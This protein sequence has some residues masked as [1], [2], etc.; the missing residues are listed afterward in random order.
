[1]LLQP[2]RGVDLLLDAPARVVAEIDFH[3]HLGTEVR[4]IARA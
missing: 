2:D 4:Q 3:P 1:V